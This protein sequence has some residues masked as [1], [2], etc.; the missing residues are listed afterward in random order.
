MHARANRLRRVALPA[1]L[2]IVTLILSQCTMVGDNVTGVDLDRAARAQCKQDCQD[3]H[4][5]CLD[6][7]EHDCGGI[8]NACYA[9]AE[10]IC[11]AALNECS[12]NCNHKQGSGIVG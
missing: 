6:Q 12:K 8:G 1:L 9:A 7:A 5:A 2:G 3:A 11:D 4:H 10:A